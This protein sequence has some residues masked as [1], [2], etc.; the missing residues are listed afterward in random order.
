MLD[1][2]NNEGCPQ[3]GGSDSVGVYV[4]SNSQRLFK[5]C[6]KCEEKISG[7]SD[8]KR[9]K[10]SA[11]S[12]PIKG[13]AHNA[14]IERR[15]SK[16][17]ALK[18]DVVSN[19]DIVVF[20]LYV[21]GRV[22]GS[23]TRDFN[24]PKSN[25]S[26]HMSISGHYSGHL[27]GWQS[28]HT[29]N[30]VGIALGEF[31]AMSITEVTGIPC[32]SPTNGDG[33]L[34]KC[35]K[36]DFR[37]LMKFEKIVFVEDKANGKET[38]TPHEYVEEAV[39]LLGKD[40]CYIAQPSLSDPNAY[41]MQGKGNLLKQLFY[42]ASSATQNLFYES[43]IDLIKPVEMGRFSG[44]LPFDKLV[45]GIRL[46][47]TTYVIGA[48]GKG[49][50]TFVQNLIWSLSTKGFK[51]CIAALETGA[52]DFVTGLSNVFYGGNIDIASDVEREEVGKKIDSS[53]IVS[54]LSIRNTARDLEST[55]AAASKIHGCNVA[56]VDNITTAANPH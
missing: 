24:F 9:S 48:P 11:C 29:K 56:V 54:K 10:K 33:S 6:Y 15:L 34:L 25:K 30:I 26:C 50:T 18:Y 44:V 22:I 16:D 32:L 28:V 8:D 21:N 19:G 52:H 7:V 37:R 36:G 47:E 3:C 46:K 53:C 45:G 13:F 43:S 14:I 20:P 51:V 41:L 42:S 12:W 38:K 31:D 1:Y 17:T 55:L 4:D 23:K 49:K 39:E 5:Y 2:R 35:I 40:K 27:W